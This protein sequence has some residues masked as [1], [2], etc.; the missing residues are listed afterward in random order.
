MDIKF[1]NGYLILLISLSLSLNINIFL[2]LEK[3]GDDVIH[4]SVAFFPISAG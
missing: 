4:Q 2:F 3:M 1:N